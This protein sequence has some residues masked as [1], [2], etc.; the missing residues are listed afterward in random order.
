MKRRRPGDCDWELQPDGWVRC[1]RCLKRKRQPTRRNC[2]YV[3]LALGDRVAHAAD[4]IG[5]APCVDCRGRQAALNQVGRI[6]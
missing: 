2:P 1:V 5:F 6:Q 3:G 4:A